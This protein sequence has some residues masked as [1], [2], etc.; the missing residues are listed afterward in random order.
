MTGSVRDFFH[1]R[2]RER[3]STRFRAPK[4]ADVQTDSRVKRW[5]G[6]AVA[7]L[8]VALLSLPMTIPLGVLALSPLGPE[9]VG[10][11][12][13]AGFQ[14]SIFAGFVSAL[15][16]GSRFQI[17]GPRASI[18]LIMA[19]A[20]T[21]L[22]ADPRI[23][24][25]G[26]RPEDAALTIGFMIVFCAGVLQVGLGVA[27]IGGGI[28][29]VPYPVLSGFMNGVA[30]LIALG[31]LPAALGLT[32]S[33]H[34]YDIQANASHISPLTVLVTGFTMLV[35]GVTPRL[36]KAVPPI[37][38]ALLAG[39][40][41][42]QALRL[43]FGAAVGPLVGHIDASL[44]HPVA[45]TAALTLSSHNELPGL[46]I[47]Q[48]PFIL[49]L[50]LV[51]SM[52]SLLSATA[53]DIVTATHHDS[54]REL[55][56]QG[57]GNMVAACFGGVAST[58]APLRGIASY[59]AGGRSRWAGALHSVFLALALLGG[60]SLLEELPYAVMAAIMMM[61]AVSMTDRWIFDLL[62]RGGRDFLPDFLIVIAVAGATVLINLAAAVTIGIVIA[63][64][65][66][67]FGMSRPIVRSV[68]DRTVS[69]S[70]RV[71]PLAVEAHLERRG[72]EM[73]VVELDGALFFG[74]AER[75]RH[76][77]E[78]LSASRPRVVILD[79]RRVGHID[80][81]GV[82][83]LQQLGRAS[84]ARGCRILLAGFELNGERGRWLTRAGIAA[85]IPPNQWYSTR[86]RAMEAA[87]D[88]FIE[89]LSTAD[90]GTAEVADFE[91]MRSI[92]PADIHFL[93]STMSRL[94][95]QVGDVLFVKGAPCDGLY[96]L[97][98]GLV[99]IRSPET[100]SKPA[101]RRATFGS[102]TL[103][104]ERALIS[105]DT[106]SADAVVVGA[107]EVYHLPMARFIAFRLSHPLAA[108]QLALNIGR[109][110][111][112]RLRLANARL[113]AAE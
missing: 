21:A 83:I 51:A 27:R 11:G 71:R 102:G 80:L 93:K 82:R 65:Q 49:A 89:H 99:E 44:P 58:G 75:L 7:G 91:I 43:I 92:A 105:G 64:M 72:K 67:V 81:S 16:G 110:L 103:L 3:L 4:T 101:I 38:L 109:E 35:L 108:T 98:S 106:Q 76:E 30:I 39:V 29:F 9:Y 94:H 57:A 56:G 13:L 87:E 70:R 5:R 78:R 85:T 42:D 107:A 36:T 50:T 12:V 28:R 10:A 63:V 73:I 55:I 79:M 66:F 53:L 88:Q 37:V 24:A 74:T 84:V 47:S 60:T 54:N 23:A 96:F 48:I 14:S 61:I 100:D 112:E 15:S 97:V 6:D 34:W 18:S 40:A 31:Q 25:L 86:D 113:Q 46:M 62:R 68:Y 111:G 45:L 104:G 22:L 52:E 32:A 41:F 59:R 2:C 77:L 8:V 26:L 95:Y 33:L 20:L 17:S 90:F 19:S 69:K 1:E